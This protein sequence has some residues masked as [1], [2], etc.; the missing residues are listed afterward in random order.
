MF[1]SPIIIFSGTLCCRQAKI[2]HS[3]RLKLTGYMA[4]VYWTS[5]DLALCK[6]EAHRIYGGRVLGPVMFS[7]LI[8]LFSDTLSCR[9]AKILHSVRLK[10][11][12]YMA[13]VYWVQ[14]CSVA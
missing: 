14:S 3:V 13:D 2:L 6:I 5:E 1:S 11:T 4:D 9:Q 10:L 12:G 8:I 7:I